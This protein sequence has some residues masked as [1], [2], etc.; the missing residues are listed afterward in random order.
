[1]DRASKL[2]LDYTEMLLRSY[3]RRLADPA[4][5]RESFEAKLREP[6]RAQEGT[7]KAILKRHATSEYGRRYRFEEIDSY[8]AYRARVPV[9][10]YEDI[11]ED[12]QRMMRGERDVL[13]Q[14]AA[15]YFSTTSGSMAAPKFIPGTQQTIA[16]GC[17]A[18]MARNA[19]LFHHHPRSA[20]GRPLFIVGNAVEGKTAMGV[21]YGAMTGFAYYVGHM[22]FPGTPFPYDVFTVPD[23][24]SRYYC[25][26][27]LALAARDLS[28]IFVYNSSTLPLLF[29]VALARWDELLED[30]G[31]GGLTPKVA[32]PRDLRGALESSLRPDPRR[33]AELR[34]LKDA[35]PRAWWPGLAVL[36]CW[37]GGS[38]GFY[39]AQLARWIGDLPVR[40]FGILA[41]EVLLTIGVDDVTAGGVLLPESGFFEFVPKGEGLESARGAHELEPGHEYRV[42]ITTHGGLYRYDLEDVV[43]VEGEH[44]GMPLLSF[45]HR[46]GRVHSFTGEK[47]TEYQVTLAVQAAAQAI[48]VRLRGFVAIPTWHTPPYYEVRAELD[49]ASPWP[50]CRTLSDRIDEELRAVNIEYASKRDSGR[51]GRAHL[52]LVA[53]GGFE[54][55]RRQCSEQ[56]GQYKQIHLAPHPGFGSE[57]QIIGWP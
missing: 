20:L 33:A 52:A 12:V 10:R 45:R 49:G 6:R 13:I 27:R 40:D 57:L 55:L 24:A 48:G 53:P 25:I 54:R 26:L 5:V 19:Y 37:K 18:I 41:S 46:A 38:L 35:G 17:D 21:T 30:V 32:L 9:V 2:R 3:A 11:R 1:M 42:L 22:G 36:M 31:S 14:G 8:E 34:L 51:L 29:E 16:A 28:A 39:Q 15:S 44:A 4:A 56:D 47:L 50:L 23:Y 7:L 43:R